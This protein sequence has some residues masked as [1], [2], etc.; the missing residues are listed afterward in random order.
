MKKYI[1]YMAAA[2][3]GVNMT[4]C[5][6]FLD[7]EVDLT[8]SAEAVFDKFENTRGLLANIYTYLPDAFSGYTNGQFLA[9]S[10]DCMTDNAISFWNVHYYHAV[11]SDAYDAT[12]HQFSN[13]FWGNNFKAI[14]ACNNFLTYAKESV[15]KNKEMEGDDNRLYDR[16]MAEARLLRAIF[17]MELVAW[18]GD[19][20]IVGED[21]EGKPII[22][23]YTNTAAMNQPRTDAAEVLKWIAN[24]CDKVKDVLPFRYQQENINWGRVNGAA[25]YAL[26]SRALLYRASK[27]NNP[28]NDKSWWTEAATAAKDFISKNAAST[29]PYKLYTTEDNDINENYYQCFVSTPHLNNEYI[30][31][32]SEWNTREI[33]MFNTPCGFKGSV[34]STGRTNPT[35]NLV[36]AYEMAN[37]L[38]IDDPNSG[39]DEQNPYANRDPRLEQTIL[40]HGSIWGNAQEEE[41]RPVDVTYGIGADY[42][43]LH[44]GT[45]TG[46]YSKKFTNKMSFK[47]P[48]NYWHACPI[49]RYAEILL[50]A[51]E[52]VNESEGPDAAYK[53][54]NE[55]RARVGMPAYSG[56]SQDKLRERIQNE[57]RIELCFEDHRFF[58]ERRWMLFEGKSASTEKNLPRYQQVYNIYGMQVAENGSFS[59]VAAGLHPTRAFRSPKNYVLPIPDAETKRLPA[60]GQN[61]GWELREAAP[62]EP[63]IPEEGGEGTEGG[64]AT[65][66]G[67]TAGAR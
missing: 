42:Q 30:L 50:N 32:R 20:P 39:Y 5:S 21:A 12:N 7:K 51:A 55:V 48:T 49:F 35:Q 9:A 45:V 24:E 64:E 1:K 26:K 53:Y 25:A 29:N 66:G 28:T 37:G 16:Y 41:E 13:M 11:Q 40:H 3:I 62:Q 27:L 56:M 17:H 6:D 54:V 44:G 46:Y 67:E 34:N 4:A 36:D 33:E 18:F 15:I 52:A 65:E 19:A 8:L 22:F 58:D 47:S 60:I 43:E 14:R 59:V 10:R 2:L 23:D 61:P 31:S 38:P 57:R 63:T